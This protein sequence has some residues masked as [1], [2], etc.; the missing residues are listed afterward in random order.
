[1]RL[2][3]FDAII[4]D[5][6]IFLFSYIYRKRLREDL[7]HRSVSRFTIRRALNSRSARKWWSR[8]FTKHL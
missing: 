4:L 2:W 5:I 8:Y 1:M 3:T 6:L 7:R